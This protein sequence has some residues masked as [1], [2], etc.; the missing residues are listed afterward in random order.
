MKLRPVDPATTK[1]PVD[2]AASGTTV[3]IVEDDAETLAYAARTL[4]QLGIATLTFGS[5]RP[6]QAAIEQGWRFDVL[7]TDLHLGPGRSGWDLAEFC[8][9]HSPNA[10][11]VVTSGR[12]ADLARV[13]DVLKGR[14]AILEKPHDADR[15][16]SL[17]SEDDR[18]ADPHL[19]LQGA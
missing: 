19:T 14:I 3:A 10:A 16:R 5:F 9:A 18:V 6:A 4:R 15:L 17:L 7:L 2:P 8:L 1:P 12:R 13:P 11:V